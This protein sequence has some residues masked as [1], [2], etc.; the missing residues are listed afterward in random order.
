MVGLELSKEW[1]WKTQPRFLTCIDAINYLRSAESVTTD[2][3]VKRPYAIAA[4]KPNFTT[5]LPEI[6][7]TQP[8]LSPTYTTYKSLEKLTAPDLAQ[9]RLP[10]PSNI[11][12][13]ELDLAIHC[14]N[15]HSRPDFPQTLPDLTPRGF[16]PRTMCF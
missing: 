1:S 16:G 9:P 14:E 4:R 11:P 7:K 10:N 12:E 13:K 2:I 5:L 6:I 8:R 15:S 3:V